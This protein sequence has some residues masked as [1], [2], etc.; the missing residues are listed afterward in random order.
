[1]NPDVTGEHAGRI[2]I[3]DDSPANLQLLTDMLVGR[4]HTVHPATDGIAA[5]QY[6]RK[7]HPD[8]ILLDIVMPRIDGYKV[9]R[10]LKDY[11]ET[12]EI[13]IVFMTSL[14]ETSDKVK[15]FRMGAADYIT[16]PFQAEEVMARVETLLS[17]RDMQNKLKS[18]NTELLRANSDLAH[19]NKA[20]SREIIERTQAETEL[21]RYREQLEDL[22]RER[23][24]ELAEANRNLETEIVERKRAEERVT[25]SLRE[26][27][28]LLREVHHR[29]K[30]NLQI[31]SALL[32]LQSDSIRDE[33]SLS[34]FRESQER[35]KAMALVHERLYKSKD[36]ASVDFG[37]YVEHLTRH[38][39]VSYVEDPDRLSVTVDTANF[40]LDIEEAIPCGL[41]I[42]ELI[43][44]ALK[45]AF[46]GG[47][48]G[49]IAVSCHADGEGVITIEVRD[50]GVGLPSGLDLMNTETLG[51]QIVAML[52]RQL[53]GSIEVKNDNGASFMVTFKACRGQER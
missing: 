32:D 34:L 8:L 46:P 18:R 52:T 33:E 24:A 51:L 1:M 38:L 50:T 44:N 7:E 29:V 41:I 45:H 11:E 2:L 31:I 40:S 19:V 13:P 9:C 25:A 15:G 35:I 27:E 3:V 48:K 28:I 5:L 43:S 22:V 17:L 16:K 10:F 42:N 30:N 26:K 4:G 47:R 21:K 14:A 23:T 12:R 49:E 6:A 39:A 53:R 37:E 20:L 36:F